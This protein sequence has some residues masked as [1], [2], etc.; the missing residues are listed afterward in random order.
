M[1]EKQTQT[2]L[3]YPPN[4]ETLNPTI[5]SCYFPMVFSTTMKQWCLESRLDVFGHQKASKT[6]WLAAETEE[7]S[8]AH[9]SAFSHIG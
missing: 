8:V 7:L 1:V 9:K 3:H 4:S 6:S 5:N 2:Q